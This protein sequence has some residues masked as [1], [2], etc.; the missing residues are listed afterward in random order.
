MAQNVVQK[1]FFGFNCS[2][3]LCFI[4]QTYFVLSRA[5]Q[6]YSSTGRHCCIQHTVYFFSTEES[7]LFGFGQRGP[8]RENLEVMMEIQWAPLKLGAM[9][10]QKVAVLTGVVAVQWSPD[11]TTK[12]IIR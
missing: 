2:P 1:K 11:L 10:Q 7:A 6:L 4:S 5:F 3:K 12:S 8:L 9:D